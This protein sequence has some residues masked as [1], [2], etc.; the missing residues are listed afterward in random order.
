[1]TEPRE[2]IDR[3]RELESQA[4]F[5]DELHAHLND[6]VARQ[7]REIRDLREQL[8]KLSRR[9]QEIGEALPGSGPGQG[10]ELP[11]HY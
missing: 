5:Q 2:I 9:L 4:A 3:L 1:M 7:D 6:V 8:N 11:P 10:D